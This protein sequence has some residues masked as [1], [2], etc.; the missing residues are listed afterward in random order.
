MKMFVVSANAGL[1]A[2]E[3]MAGITPKLER[4]SCEW[5][6]WSSEKFSKQ[7]S[8]NHYPQFVQDFEGFLWTPATN[9][10]DTANWLYLKVSHEDIT[11]LLQYHSQKLWNKN[12]TCKSKG[13]LKKK[14]NY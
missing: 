13:S 10:T 12:L 11:E 4:G 6:H 9:V 1:I 5:Q 8:W 2:S 3:E 7:V 14:K